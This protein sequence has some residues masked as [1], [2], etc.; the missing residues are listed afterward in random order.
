L[1][2]DLSF[3]PGLKKELMLRNESLKGKV[4]SVTQIFKK[5]G[6]NKG[7]VKIFFNC[8]DTRDYALMGGE[9]DFFNTTARLV[10]VLL[11]REVRRCFNCQGYG[12]SQASCRDPVPRCGKCA[13][14]NRTR[15]FSSN[16]K[17]CANCSDPHEAGDRF[18]N[19][20]MKAVAR[21]RIRLEHN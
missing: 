6:T 15:D 19:V 10:E 21:Y 20:Q 17:Q 13:G 11:D 1:F 4:D 3:L 5:P 8:Q 9:V 2:V 14:A 12:H 18:C 7:H 16:V